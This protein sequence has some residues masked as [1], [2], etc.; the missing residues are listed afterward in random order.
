MA[1]CPGL[2]LL[3]TSA[4]LLGSASDVHGVWD[5]WLKCWLL[6]YGMQKLNR[7]DMC[8]SLWNKFLHSPTTRTVVRKVL[9]QLL[10]QN[11]LVTLRLLP[12]R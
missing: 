9:L 11:L 7:D 8:P 6:R 5:F 10:W 1:V 12:L 2:L 4:C 3:S